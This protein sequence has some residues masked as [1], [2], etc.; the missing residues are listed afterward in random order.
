MTSQCS[1]I[2]LSFTRN[3]STMA[4]PFGVGQLKLLTCNTTRSSSAITRTIFPEGGE[5]SSFGGEAFY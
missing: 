2:L 1:T 5:V 3:I 4:P